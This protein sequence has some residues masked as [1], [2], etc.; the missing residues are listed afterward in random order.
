MD[1]A[2]QLYN[3]LVDIIKENYNINEDEFLKI[4]KAYNIAR[5]AH[6]NQLRKSGEP[7]IIHP[8]AVSI[9]LANLKMDVSSIIA[10][11]LHDIIEDTDYSFLDISNL[12]SEEVAI[13]VD[14]VTKL[15]KMTYSSK[16]E[17]QA[18]NYR[19]MFL[20]MAKDIRVILIKFADR[21]HNMRTLNYMSEKKQKEKAQET[22]DI[23][24]PIA[25]KLGI[26]KIKSELE[27][28]SLRYIYPEIYYDLA[29]K[30]KRKQSEREKYVLKV[31]EELKEKTKN[32]D[33]NCKVY[34]R[35]KHFFSIYR[36][37]V[38]SGKTFDQIY[39]LFAI[40]VIVDSV[41]DCYGVLGIVHE[42][43]KPI[44]GRFKDYI[45][46]PKENMY[47]SLHNSLIGPEGM[48]F[49]IQIRT[50][51]MHQIAEYGIA[52]HWK[53]K[54]GG[55][56]TETQTQQEKLAWLRQILEIQENVDDNKEF[57]D[58]I[59]GNLD[60]FNDNVYCF[61]PSGEVKSLPYGSTPVDFAYSIH[62]AIGNTMVGAKVNDKI[63]TFDHKL[64]NGDRV[65]IITSQNSK[66]PSMDWFKFVKSP[67][68]KTKIKQW[69][70]KINKE[71]NIVHGHDLLEKDAKRKGLNINELIK[72]ER[73]NIILQ[74]YDFKD[75]N[76]LCAAIGHGGLKE[77]QIINK[78]NEI[79][80][81]EL[82]KT[83]TFEELLKDNSNL[84]E[85]KS[86]K[87]K[88][89]GIIIDGMEYT[90]FRMSQCCK[91]I[92]GDEIVAFITRG[93]G[94]SIH[95]TDCVNIINLPEYDSKRLA[96]AFWSKPTQN[97]SF[98]CE[99]KFTAM[100]RKNIVV[101]VIKVFTEELINIKNI[102][103]RTVRDKAIINIV[104]SI[105]T[106]SHLDLIFKRLMNL[107]GAIDIQRI[108]S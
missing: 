42:T 64:K 9:I 52:A 91:P 95:R 26:S 85:V 10:G 36:K 51:E 34:G 61:S 15:K 99:I 31:V 102:N 83:K 39:D 21:L 98:L 54:Q 7:Y 32:A 81:K 104:I 48:P 86:K 12:F 107:K 55:K 16:E 70:K 27:D 17:Q 66:G 106:K 77:G 33:I 14:G 49:E 18:E 29:I 58:N 108:N 79:Y 41:K 71:E 80:Q 69:F 25:N 88:G 24:A 56:A 1:T 30:V 57:M 46:M 44:P 43:Y 89:N 100:D 73:V 94:V 84:N 45:A 68:T 8:I 47:Q 50:W 60:I 67:Q 74:R 103:A 97:S 75:F 2:Q 101:D 105:N 82:N 38:K 23:Y 37:M 59:K 19:K 76:A 40:R 53:Y 5:E 11:L 3:Q 35:A 78:L 4:E 87:T 72:P 13:L 92:H 28:L 62:S 93:R 90:D 22:I 20:T 65:S 96:E 6:Q 63:V